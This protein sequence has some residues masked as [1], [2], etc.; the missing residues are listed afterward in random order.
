LSKFQAQL[1]DIHLI[2][3]RHWINNE[4]DMQ[5]N[6]NKD[7]AQTRTILETY[8]LSSLLTYIYLHIVL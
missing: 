7:H 2:S 6:K 5:S 1:K 3:E 4:Y 8:V